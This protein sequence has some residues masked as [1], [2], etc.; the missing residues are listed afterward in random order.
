MSMADQL[1]L[2]GVLSGFYKS[3]D[4]SRNYRGLPRRVPPYRGML[5]AT[6]RSSGAKLT[7][8]GGKVP[9]GHPLVR[10]QLLEQRLR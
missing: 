1:V 6:P 3:G 8:L 10:A 2:L 4:T 9:P 5:A 7:G